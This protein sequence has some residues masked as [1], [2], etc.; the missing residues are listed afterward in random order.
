[1]LS[2]D[3]I[4]KVSLYNFSSEGELLSEINHLI[5]VFNLD[6]DQIT[7]VYKSRK[8]VS[9]YLYY[10][11]VTNLPRVKQAIER[12]TDVLDDSPVIEFGAGP[13][14]LPMALKDHKNAFYLIENSS[15]M[16]ESGRAVLKEYAPK[17][18]F[19]Y[20]KTSIDVPILKDPVLCFTNS[21]NELDSHDFWEL[22][23]QLKPGKI[24]FIEPGTKEVFH[25]L[26]EVRGKLQSKEY[27]VTYPCSSQVACPLEGTEDWCHQYLKL[28][29]DPSIERLTQ[30]LKRNRRMVPLCLHLFEKEA[31]GAHQ[32]ILFSRPEVR[33]Y[34]FD[35]R[36]CEGN[37]IKKYRVLKKLETYDKKRI[38]ALLPGEVLSFQLLKN[39]QIE[40]NW[41]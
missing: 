2:K 28:V 21:F 13:G 23:D 19:Q 31:S 32:A 27:K 38:S 25:R 41:S 1:M 20:F 14:T 24:I 8:S 34:G 6:R 37:E 30:K 35:L 11:Y 3:E 26:L 39:D 9:A 33:K 7:D 12:L 22:I 29:H 5:E 10:F 36:I 4:D 40:I 17:V 18:N 16:Q 15:L